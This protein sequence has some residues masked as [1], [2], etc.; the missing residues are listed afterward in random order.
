M[1]QIQRDFDCIALLSEHEREVGGLYDRFLLKFIPAH[2]D[3][4]LEVGCGTGAFTRLLAMQAN[5]VTAIDLSGEMI[6]VARRRSADYPHIEYTVGNFL[7]LDIPHSHFDCAV[8]IATLHHLPTD[9]VLGKLEQTLKPGGALVLHD[10]LTPTGALARSADLIRFPVSLGTRWVR[11]G[12]L[13]EKRK[14][15]NAWTAHGKEE[16]YPGKREVLAMR[17]KYLPGGYVKYHFLWRYT[18][19]WHKRDTT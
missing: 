9:L 3:R 8:M 15:R 18:V 4:V 10:L 12:R 13:W 14:L 17:D 19:V 2:S 1:Q 11:T 7:E 5:H 6:R 16:R